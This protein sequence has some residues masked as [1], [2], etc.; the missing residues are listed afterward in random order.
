MTCQGNGCGTVFQLSRAENGAWKLTTLF[1]FNGADGASPAAGLAMNAKGNLYGTTTVD[2]TSGDG[3]V[4]EL[5][6]SVDKI[7]KFTTILK[8]TA[9]NGNDP[10]AHLILDAVGNLYG[11]TAGGGSLAC[12]AGGCGTVFRL[13][14]AE[15]WRLEAH[16]TLH[17]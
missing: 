6:P 7:W 12:Q 11:I 14:R 10:E 8:F 9:E 13:S 15:K 5:S 16:Y 4:F 17:S 3:T 1:K 2:G